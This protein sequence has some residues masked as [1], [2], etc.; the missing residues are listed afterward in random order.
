MFQ[1]WQAARSPSSIRQIP[2]HVENDEGAVSRVPAR[3][4]VGV[5]GELDGRHVVQG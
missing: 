5:V 2:V 1:L 3:G 4:R